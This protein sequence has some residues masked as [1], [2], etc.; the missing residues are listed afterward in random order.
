MVGSFSVASSPLKQSLCTRIDETVADG[1]EQKFM[2]RLLLI[3]VRL[4]KLSYG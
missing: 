2:V 3:G 1:V 4:G